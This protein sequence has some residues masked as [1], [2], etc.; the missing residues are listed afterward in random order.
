M[1]IYLLCLVSLIPE[2]VLHHHHARRWISVDSGGGAL[3]SRLGLRA[4][5]KG[6]ADEE[7]QGVE[8]FWCCG[9]RPAVRWY[10]KAVMPPLSCE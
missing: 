7:I 6:G 1:H 4:I 10:N 5:D 8:A 3:G 9:G 2:L